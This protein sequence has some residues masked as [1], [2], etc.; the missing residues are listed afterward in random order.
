MKTQENYSTSYKE[1]NQK[2]RTVAADLRDL[3]EELFVLQVKKAQK[4]K[5][6]KVLLNERKDI[7]E[8]QELIKT[9]KQWN[10]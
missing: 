2:I 4:I 5:Y 6:L 7:K 8:S 1:V 9:I 10:Q 3:E